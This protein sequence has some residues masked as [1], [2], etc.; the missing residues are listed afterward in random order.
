MVI[1]TK[2]QIFG[3]SSHHNYTGCMTNLKSLILSI[4]VVL[5]VLAHVRIAAE[6][7]VSVV[8]VYRLYYLPFSKYFLY[9]SKL[10]FYF[11]GYRCLGT[12]RFCIL[13]LLRVL[14]FMAMTRVLILGRSALSFHGSRNTQAF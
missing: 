12:L 6:P 9:F 5:L 1:K 11:F 3:K 10:C 14:C 7:L 8:E 13:L 2:K 4:I